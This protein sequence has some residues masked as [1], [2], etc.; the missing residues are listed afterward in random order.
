[1]PGLFIGGHAVDTSQLNLNDHSSN[2]GIVRRTNITLIALVGFFVGLRLFVRAC[3]VRN[4]FLDDVLIL[5]A[6][7]FTIVLAAVC[8]AATG[9]GLGTHVWMLNFETI[10]DTIKS[11]IQYLFVCQIFYACAIAFTKISII[12]SYLHLIKDPKFR[13]AMYSTAVVIVGLWFSGVLVTVFQCRPVSAVWDFTNPNGKCI[14]FVDYLYASSAVTIATD[15]VLCVLPWPY[16]W[17]LQLPLK[18]RIILC[19]LL[20]GGVGASVASVMRIAKLHMLRGVDVTY[21]SVPSLN[22]SVIE[23]SLGIICVSIPPLRPLAVRLFPRPFQS[24]RGPSAK[25]TPHTISLSRL[26]ANTNT[27]TGRQCEPNARPTLHRED[28][29]SADNRGFGYVV[30]VTSSPQKDYLK[31]NS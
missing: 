5:V 13:I 7:A 30:Q 29:L 14:N 19:L 21:V 2:V 23:C 22:L 9:H 12:A 18:Q 3:I 10:I 26:S 11:S 17:R 28:S 15:L 4:I 6:A 16:I 31:L 1:M 8:I 27:G 25:S 20:S 24:R